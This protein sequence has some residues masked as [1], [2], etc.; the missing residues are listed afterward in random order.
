MLGRA[1]TVGV[2]AGLAYTLSP[3][4]VA[5][6]VFAA[7]LLWWAGC[8]LDAGERRWVLAALSLGMALRVAAIGALLLTTDVANQDFN[9]FF[10][11]AHAAITR[12]WWIRNLWL[13]IPIG[14][15]YL[16][17]AYDPY[18]ATPYWLVLAALQVII[19]AS[20]YGLNFISTA[21]F[22]AG[23]VLLHRVVR[24]SYGPAV[25]LTGL[26]VLLFWPTTLA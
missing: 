23:A 15:D 22:L 20:P 19:G 8:G 13:G 25:A 7:V 26:V 17:A 18:G 9:A 21:A 4:T 24:E 16:H 2:L 11:D 5:F 10:P 14:P 12:T 1:L 3:L 6:A